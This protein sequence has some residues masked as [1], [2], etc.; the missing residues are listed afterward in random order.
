MVMRVLHRNVME[1]VTIETGR[2][3]VTPI[4]KLARI[5][6]LFLYQIIRLFDGDVTLRT[7]GEKDMPLLQ[8]WLRDLCR[9]RENLGDLAEL[10]DSVVKALPPIEWEVSNI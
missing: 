4:E 5:Q 8:T 10:E 6:S 2:S 7:L 3:V 9:V 1:L